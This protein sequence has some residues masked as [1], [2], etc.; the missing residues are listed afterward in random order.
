MQNEI[1][2]NNFHPQFSPLYSNVDNT[3]EISK[4]VKKESFLYRRYIMNRHDEDWRTDS[5]RGTRRSRKSKVFWIPLECICRV[6][7]CR[8][9]CW[10]LQDKC[11]RRAEGEKEG[12]GTHCKLNLKAGQM[13]AV[14]VA[15]APLFHPS[16]HFSSWPGQTKEND[17]GQPPGLV[18]RLRNLAAITPLTH[19]PR[20]RAR[21][22]VIS[23]ASDRTNASSWAPRVD[24]PPP[25]LRDFAYHPSPRFESRGFRRLSS[26]LSSSLAGRKKE[27][28]K[29]GL[30]GDVNGGNGCTSTQSRK[31]SV[32]KSG[33]SI[34]GWHNECPR[35][36]FDAIWIHVPLLSYINHVY[37]NL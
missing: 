8:D 22:R 1:T 5:P 18:F 17:C 12:E 27:R 25:E 4:I 32:G 24:S 3:F 7:L 37:R 16:W 14:T 33:G 15:R 20:P 9:F 35:Y 30:G 29:K 28:G 19:Y 31:C 11:R 36:Y 13:G 2:P 26:F 6:T 34:A 21:F 23:S 10:W